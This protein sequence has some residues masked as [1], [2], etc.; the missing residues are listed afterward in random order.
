M[1]KIVMKGSL[2]S[3]DSMT[4]SWECTG[5]SV[6]G[7]H[8]RIRGIKIQATP[9]PW[10]PWRSQLWV[11]DRVG[12]QLVTCRL[13][14]GFVSNAPE[15]CEARG[16]HSWGL[17]AQVHLFRSSSKNGEPGED[18][19]PFCNFLMLEKSL[20]TPGTVLCC[21]FQ[22]RCCPAF[23]PFRLTVLGPQ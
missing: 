21:C 18:L 22:W 4:C 8:H 14:V 5:G 20:L 3:H 17:S 16:L 11:A 19:H 23:W 2:F 13:I 9:E 15:T 7:L 6:I 10:N 12:A 1:F